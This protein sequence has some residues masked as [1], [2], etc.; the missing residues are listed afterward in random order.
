[1]HM[2]PNLRRRSSVHG[3]KRA[4]HLV[5]DAAALLTTSIFAVCVLS[6]LS[7]AQE[8]GSRPGAAV[9]TLGQCA[10]IVSLEGRLV[11]EQWARAG[12]CARPVRTRVTDRFLGFTCLENLPESRTCRSFVPPPG[13]SEFDSSHFFRCVD[14]AVTDTD[15]GIVVG[16]MKEW[17][18]PSKECDWSRSVEVPAMEVDFERGEACAGGLCILVDRL[19]GIG[20]LRLRRLIEKAFRELGIGTVV[21]ARSPWAMRPLW[22]LDPLIARRAPGICR[23]LRD[24]PMFALDLHQGGFWYLAHSVSSSRGRR[25][26]CG[27]ATIG[28]CPGCFSA[29]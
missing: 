18:A 26:S 5:K 2:T 11:M 6:A 19:S 13:S 24:R 21:G 22:S 9:E 4:A 12:A 29:P 17:V 10:S 15:A 20:K 1:M 8:S 3:T 23:W 16:R 27:G 7:S 14:M 28:R 25:T